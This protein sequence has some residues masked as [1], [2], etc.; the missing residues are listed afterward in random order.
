MPS[1]LTFVSASCLFTQLIFCGVMPPPGFWPLWPGRNDLAD[2]LLPV[3]S[4]PVAG[5]ASIAPSSAPRFPMVQALTIPPLSHALTLV[6]AHRPPT[7]E[8][9]GKIDQW[10]ASP[11]DPPDAPTGLPAVLRTPAGFAPFPAVVLL[12]DCGGPF[13]GMPDW[14][15]RLNAWGYAVL[16]PDSLSPRGVHTGCEPADQAKVTPLDRVGDLAAA[17]A[18]LRTRP[19]IDPDRIAVL[20]LS[21]GGV[22]AV[23]ATRSVYQGIRLR[24]AVDYNGSCEEPRLHGKVP[25]LVL[26]GEDR[27]DPAASCKEFGAE[28]GPGQPFEIHTYP[29]AFRGT[30]GASAS[31]APATGRGFALDKA[32]AEDS[33]ARARSF[34]DRVVKF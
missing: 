3:M 32:A 1:A 5:G 6:S 25:L 11:T 27:D 26:A 13:T 10:G 17:V 28:L 34:L 12:H 14:A 22:T 4:G 2:D 24:A 18:W 20:G 16:M 9:R 33:F 23:I 30:D 29:G 21:H 31:R 19:D 8:P 15:Y 7:P